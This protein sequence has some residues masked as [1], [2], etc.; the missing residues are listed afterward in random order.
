MIAVTSPGST[1]TKKPRASPTEKITTSATNIAATTAPL[2][3]FS[4]RLRTARIQMPTTARMMVAPVR[5]S[6]M[7]TRRLR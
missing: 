7:S 1:S 2:Y 5:S 3:L 4:G 6:S